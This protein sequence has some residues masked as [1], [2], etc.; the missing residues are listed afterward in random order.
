MFRINMVI[1]WILING[2]YTILIMTYATKDLIWI[3]AP[4]HTSFIEG[5]SLYLAGMVVFK[6]TCAIVH[7]LRMKWQYNC[8]PKLAIPKFNL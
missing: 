7:I 4:G 8:N 5:L 2:L 3:N 1:F 6:V